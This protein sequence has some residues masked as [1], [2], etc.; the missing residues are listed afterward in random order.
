LAKNIK[1][2]QVEAYGVVP[3]LVLSTCV[4]IA[5]VQVHVLVPTCVGVGVGKITKAECLPM[6]S[7]LP[8]LF[9]FFCNIS[10]DKG[11]Y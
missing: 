10:I 5:Q 3:L 9:A 1:K 2:S 11:S 7:T 6:V 4:K 8:F